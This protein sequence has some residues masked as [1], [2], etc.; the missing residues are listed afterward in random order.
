MKHCIQRHHIYKIYYIKYVLLDFIYKLLLKIQLT[1][2]YYNSRNESLFAEI[3]DKICMHI[4]GYIATIVRPYCVYT[5]SHIATIL[6]LYCIIKG[7]LLDSGYKLIL[8]IQLTNKYS[9]NTIQE[10]SLYFKKPVTKYTCIFASILR[11]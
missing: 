3:S 6:R 8:K 4:S 5:V 9:Y 1:N 10:M 11:P 2:K 7:L